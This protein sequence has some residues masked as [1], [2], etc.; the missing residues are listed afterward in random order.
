LTP[1]EP[2]SL[3]DINEPEK[4]TRL[5][6]D[7]SNNESKYYQCGVLCVPDNILL[8]PGFRFKLGEYLTTQ[9]LCV[10]E[11]DRPI[12]T[13][14]CFNAA[15]LVCRNDDTRLIRETL[16][17]LRLEPNWPAIGMIFGKQQYEPL[18]IDESLSEGVILE[19]QILQSLPLCIFEHSKDRNGRLNRKKIRQLNTLCTIG[20]RPVP[21]HEY[22]AGRYLVR[23]I[24]LNC[25]RGTNPSKLDIFCGNKRGIYREGFHN[26]I[27]DGQEYDLK[28]NEEGPS[29]GIVYKSSDTVVTDVPVESE[30]ALQDA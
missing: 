21:V 18:W 5:I 14:A 1:D 6:S 8:P 10:Y 22:R 28:Y 25:P 3:K 23:A 17:G 29:I 24:R 9:E 15:G 12:I 7:W 26:S 27:L 20:N 19:D 30:D 13:P 16:N 11:L 4:V 2:I